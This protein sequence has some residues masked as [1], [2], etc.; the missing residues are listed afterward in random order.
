[1]GLPVPR[2]LQGARSVLDV[3]SKLCSTQAM[4]TLSWVS[5]N[6]PRIPRLVSGSQ[7]LNP[8]L[9]LHLGRYLPCMFSSPRLWPLLQLQATCSVCASEAAFEK[10]QVKMRAPQE[11]L[12]LFPRR[13]RGL[14]R[15]CAS[16]RCSRAV[17]LL[18]GQG[19]G[20][21]QVHLSMQ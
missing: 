11:L 10:Q 20:K 15:A 3:T 5:S 14:W 2:G 6:G 8:P 13:V 16:T 7:D 9:L 18:L 21:P 1:M 12:V 4:G 17:P 19:Q